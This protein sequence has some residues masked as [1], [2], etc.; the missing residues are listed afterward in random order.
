[1]DSCMD[2][3]HLF[4]FPAIRCRRIVRDSEK[5]IGD[6]Q[7]DGAAARTLGTDNIGVL[8]AGCHKQTHMLDTILKL[9]SCDMPG[10]FVIALASNPIANDY[11]SALGSNHLPGPRPDWWTAGCVTVTTPEKIKRID[12][13]ALNGRPVMA[14]A[15]VDPRC[16]IHLARGPNRRGYANNDRPRHIA[17]F[18]ARHSRG[19]WT[20]PMFVFTEVP[21]KSLSTDQ[22]LAPFALEAWWFL[23]GSGLRMGK[24]P[25]ESCH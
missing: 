17:T 21:A 3:D 10:Q 20:P 16:V 25:Q 18:R 15:A 13:S 7:L 5:D 2:I 22:M 14:V 4:P 9:S 6:F 1:M 8:V 11:F 12:S 24:P 19:A 23:D